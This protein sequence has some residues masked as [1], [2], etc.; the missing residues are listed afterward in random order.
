MILERNIVDIRLSVYDII[1][2]DLQSKRESE[3]YE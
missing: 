2:S 3:F 1:N